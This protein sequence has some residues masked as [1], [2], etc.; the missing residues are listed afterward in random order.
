MEVRFLVYTLTFEAFSEKYL[1]H[2][3]KKSLR[4]TKQ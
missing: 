2:N 3:L 1:Q 4:L